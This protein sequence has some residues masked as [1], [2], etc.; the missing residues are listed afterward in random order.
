MRSVSFLLA[1]ALLIGLSA[2]D[3][4]AVPGDS[5]PVVSRDAGPPPDGY[6]E[7]P[8]EP[9]LYCPGSAGCEAG[10]DPQ[11]QAG[12]AAID[13][14]PDM[15]TAETFTD[16]NGNSTWDAEDEPFVDVNGNGRFDGIWMAGFGNGRA[17]Q[18]AMNPQW[19]RALALRA[20]NTTIAFVAI[21]CIGWFYDENALIREAIEDAGIDVDYVT[22]GATHVHQARDTIG[23]WGPSISETGLDPAYQAF[24]RAQ[25]VEAVRVAVLDLEDANIQYANL[26]LRDMDTP[27][28]VN[29]YVGDNRDPNIVDDEMRMLRF[30]RAGTAT[31][32]AGSGETIGTLV[33]F[34]SHPEFQGSRNPR[35]SSDWPHWMRTAIETGIASGPDGTPVPGIGGTVIFFNGALGV[36]IGPNHM[37]AQ[38]WDGTPV[39]ED[40][41]EGAT[42]VGTQLGYFVLQALR[43][44]LTSG[45][46]TTI[47]DTA[48]LGFRRARFYVQVQNKRYHIAGQQMLFDRGLYNYDEDRPI[49][50]PTNL[51]EVYTEIAVIDVGSATM[52]T[53][54]GELDPAE[55]VGGFDAPC[56]YTPGGC[57]ALIDETRENPPDLTMAPEGPFLRDLMLARRSDASQVWLL[58]LTNDFLGYFVLDF[59]YEL[60]EGLPY[61]GEAPGAHYEET[62]SVGE[63]GWPRIREKM[64]ALIRW[65]P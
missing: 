15:T 30:V 24:V 31:A 39:E 49:R 46:E 65:S 12:V 44:A 5:G 10:G 3:G 48:T 19:A 62:N 14:T 42:V 21:D 55:F 37:H 23:I 58:G 51:P 20:G 22:V 36:Q 57:E 52:L 33:N 18:D 7:P 8:L 11:L 6:I 50:A 53:S 2:C 41:L 25:V 56:A 60:A 47:E 29:R 59:D 27:S 17:A 40:S 32:E 38:A 26:F 63:N 13:I 34:A 28:D 61:I 64:R 45:T 9:D 54:P 16:T 43:G 1:S 4:G 35:L